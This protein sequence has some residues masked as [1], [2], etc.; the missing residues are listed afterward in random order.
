MWSTRFQNQEN[1]DPSQTPNRLGRRLRPTSECGPPGLKTTQ[2]SFLPKLPD[3]YLYE[4]TEHSASKPYGLR[5]HRSPST[6]DCSGADC[7]AAGSHHDRPVGD[8]YCRRWCDSRALEYC[9]PKAAPRWPVARTGTTWPE[10][11]N[12]GPSW[13]RQCDPL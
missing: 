13:G 10:D 8:A 4:G 9:E 11:A 1:I 12:D 2:T 7:S 5:Q 3:A 6:L